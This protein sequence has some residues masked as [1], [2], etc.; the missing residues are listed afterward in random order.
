VER[1]V[2]MD[3]GI[4]ADIKQL[5]EQPTA[6]SMLRCNMLA[7][8]G[9]TACEQMPSLYEVC[10]TICERASGPAP[11]GIT[12]GN[13]GELVPA[14]LNE[15]FTCESVVGLVPCNLMT[16]LPQLSDLSQSFQTNCKQTYYDVCASEEEKATLGCSS[17]P[18]SASSGDVEEAETEGGETG[19][20]PADSAPVATSSPAPAASEE[21]AG[22]ETGEVPTEEDPTTAPAGETVAPTPAASEPTASSED[23][24]AA[25]CTDED[26][27]IDGIAKSMLRGGD[28]SLYMQCWAMT[29]DACSAIPEIY[30][31]CC[32]HCKEMSGDP[33]AGQACGNDENVL[34][35]LLGQTFTCSSLISLMDC[36]TMQMPLLSEFYASFQET[37]KLTF[38]SECATEEEKA[39]HV[40]ANAG[41]VVPGGQTDDTEEGEEENEGSSSRRDPQQDAIK[42]FQDEFAHIPNPK[43]RTA[44]ARGAAASISLLLLVVAPLVSLSAFR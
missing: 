41:V 7:M 34:D 23:A 38:Y 17:V 5:L 33:P 14:L 24:A 32:D 10:G 43:E 18:P 1:C 4:D 15:T 35:T 3:S 6:T 13:S 40:C 28:A 2:N 9:S 31:Q 25:E 29:E 11:E 22:S 44:G 36:Y 16:R 27:E 12:T 20:T 21:E 8:D 37:C 19:T 30:S 42:D 39:N 26:E